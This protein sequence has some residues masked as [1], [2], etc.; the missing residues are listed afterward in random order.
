MKK[1]GLHQQKKIYRLAN[2]KRKTELKELITKRLIKINKVN[3]EN[4]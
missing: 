2:R 4:N 3:Y 1:L